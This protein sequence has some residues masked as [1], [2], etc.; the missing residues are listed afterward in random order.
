MNQNK[1]SRNW[2]PNED[3]SSNRNDS[4]SDFLGDDGELLGGP[5]KDWLKRRKTNLQAKLKVMPKWKKALL[6]GSGLGLL[7]P[8]TA[9]AALTAAATVG[10]PTALT[11]LA[12]KKTRDAAKKALVVVKKKSAARKAAGLAAIPADAEAEQNYTAIANTPDPAIRPAPAADAAAAQT[13]VAM[14]AAAVSENKPA[15]LP[16]VPLIGIAI[17]ALSFL[18]K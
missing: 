5:V 15:A 18:K 6:I 16:I 1:C 12:L 10:V 11:A 4:F 13:A 9:T 3:F 2:E 17:G 14:H 7:M 8:M